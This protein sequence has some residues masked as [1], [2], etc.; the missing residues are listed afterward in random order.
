MSSQV[1]RAF[2][3]SLQA[4]M[5]VGTTEGRRGERPL[6]S[7]SES[8]TVRPEVDKRGRITRH[9]TFTHKHHTQGATQ[10]TT[11]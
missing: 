5:Q 9:H 11:T 1:M 2:L 10:Q 6:R 8:G 3:S 7:Q 4:R